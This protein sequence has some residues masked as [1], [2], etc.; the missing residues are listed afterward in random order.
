MKSTRKK[1]GF[2]GQRA[3]VIPRSI[4]QKQC[5]PHP[6]MS[7][8]FITDIGYYPKAKFHYRERENGADQ[9]ILI[10]CIDGKGWVRI[11][12]TI[13]DLGPGNFII[14]P[15]KTSHTYSAD[16]KS[17]W[18]IYWVHFRGKI[19]DEIIKLL[20]ETNKGF[21]NKVDY[22]EKRNRLFEE[23]YY[24]LENGYGTENLCYA[25]LCLTH[26]LSSFIFNDRF[27]I[28]DKNEKNDNI[29]ISIAF[30]RENIDK[31]LTLESIANS[32]NLSPSHYSM[33]FKKKTGFAP[34]EYFNHLK[35]QKACQYL[36]FTDLRI[37]EIA[38]KLGI[39]DQFYF[40][41]MFTKIMGKSPGEY[42]QKRQA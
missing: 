11:E 25:G 24:N 26:Y 18:T 7:N 32:A 2:D 42:R 9:H 28:I 41:R 27:T 1:E 8:Q 12:N 19:T 17:P 10:Y 38:D 30:M 37:K 33:I 23:I 16:E 29:S 21:M 36:L 35:A 40:S 15:S 31:M 6:L 13:Y 3:I 14:I 20:I 39:E 22:H 34:I 4:L 5:I